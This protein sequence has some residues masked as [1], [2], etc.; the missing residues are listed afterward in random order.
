MTRAILL[1]AGT[2]KRLGTNIPKQYIEVSGKKI[3]ENS[4]ET[5]LASEYIDSLVVAAELKWQE[6][7]LKIIDKHP[8]KDKFMGFSSPGDTRQLSVY[9]ALKFLENVVD[10]E[11]F[12]FIHDAARPNLCEALIKN[13]CISLKGHDGVI[14][15]LPMNDTVY[16]VNAEGKIS[17]LLDRNYVVAGQAPEIFMY[18]KY[19]TA[20]EKL[21]KDG[22]ILNINGSTEPAFM[23][24]MD[25]LTI[26]GDEKNYKIT[27]QADLKRFCEEKT[28]EGLE[29]F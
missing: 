23:D 26:K 7:I 2:G 6:D 18:G 12:V 29:T 22:R 4:L 3:I 1:S 27:T 8:H 15:V 19:L 28:N 14:P 24:G 5:L 21:A 11:D 20:N 16:M 9:N 10:S 13:M 25:I 17:S